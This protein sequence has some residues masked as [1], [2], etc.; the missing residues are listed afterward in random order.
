MVVVGAGSIVGSIVV[1]D[2]RGVAACSCCSIGNILGSSI[3][4]LGTCTVVGNMMQGFVVAVVESMSSY[5][6]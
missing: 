2:R 4:R 3:G 5:K 6:R 1:A